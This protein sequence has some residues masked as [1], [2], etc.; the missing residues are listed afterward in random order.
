[1]GRPVH[2]EIHAGNPE[3]A[4][5]FYR[6]VLGWTVQRW[7]TEDYWLVRT[8]PAGAPGIDGGLLPRRG[9]APAAGAPVNGYV[10]THSVD[11]ID[12]TLKLALDHHATVAVEKAVMPGVGTLAY[13]V[14]PDGNLFGILQ[15]EPDA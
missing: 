7:G 15:P 4:A 9:P 5:E 2:F 12:A 14:D 13:L 3:R 1:M 10:L 11:D 8:G 6:A